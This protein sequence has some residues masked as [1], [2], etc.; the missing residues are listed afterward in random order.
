MDVYMPLKSITLV[1]F[2]QTS[3]NLCFYLITLFCSD[4][5][6]LNILEKIGFKDSRHKLHHDWVLLN[7]VY[8][9]KSYMYYM[10]L[11]NYSWQFV[12]AIQKIF[13]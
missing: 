11:R 4:L 7:S 5:K 12:T 6:H 1:N 2:D 3:P 8:K 9:F 13:I 10:V